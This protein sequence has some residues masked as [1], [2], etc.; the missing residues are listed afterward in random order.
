LAAEQLEQR[1]AQVDRDRLFEENLQRLDR[2]IR[3]TSGSGSAS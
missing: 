3:E 2:E 1:L